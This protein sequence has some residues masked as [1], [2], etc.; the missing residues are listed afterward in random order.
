M[1]K[2]LLAKKDKEQLIENTKR[3]IFLLGVATWIA[4]FVFIF[5]VSVFKFRTGNVVYLSDTFG[6]PNSIVFIVLFILLSLLL[7]FAWK[8]LIKRGHPSSEHPTSR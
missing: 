5:G 2:E 8:Y 1:K 4:V 7:Y 6:V 3:P